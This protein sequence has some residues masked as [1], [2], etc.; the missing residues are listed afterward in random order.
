MPLSFAQRGNWAAQRLFPG[1]AAF[2]VCDLV[3]LDG[4]V[5]AGV[6]ADAVS[7]A[8]AETEALRV[9]V[10]DDD[11]APSQSV[12]GRLSLRTVVPEEVLTDEEIR[13]VV[14]AGV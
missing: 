4:P 2:C 1:S 5:D 6:F 12:G 13:A 14:R 7:G 11:G 3:W 8:F 9:V 10:Y